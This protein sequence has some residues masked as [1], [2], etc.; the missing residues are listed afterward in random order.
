MSYVGV[1]WPLKPT[2]VQ[3]ALFWQYVG[4]ARWSYN[5]ALDE[6]MESYHRGDSQRPSAIDL[7]KKLTTIKKRPETEWLNSI[8]NRVPEQSIKDA[9]RAFKRFF[10]GCRT[11]QKIGF[12]RRRAKY[13]TKPT[14]SFNVSTR[15]LIRGSRIIVPKIGTVK[16]AQ[17]HFSAPDGGKHTRLTINYQGGQWWAGV[18]YE[19]PG[20]NPVA[21][22][23]PS[24]GVDLGIAALATLSTG[25]KV[26]GPQAF[27]QEMKRLRRKNRRWAA[28]RNGS[29]RKEKKRKAIIRIHARIANVR[30]NSI[31]QLTTRLAKNYGQVVIED[32]A[33]KN[34]AKNRHLSLSIMD[35]GWGM[36]SQ[37]LKYKCPKYGSE[38]IQA[39]Q[40]Y[41][42]SKTCSGCGRK[43]EAL[44]FGQREWMCD[45]CGSKHD[46]DV[47]A[48][49]NLKNLP[50]NMRKVTPVETGGHIRR[51]ADGCQSVKREAKRL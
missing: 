29:K 32:L 21:N 43:N 14:F 15:N 46:R 23:N 50:Q 28:S 16:V 31:H 18:L 47:N 40:F 44:A 37:Q 2:A 25:E 49:I 27:R 8:S 48:A 4:T 11:G 10:L 5:W 41:P 3:E 39:N 1:K 20:M 51:K 9:D 33:I 13:K 42:S 22:G 34:M 45:G 30:S 36:F 38:L 6:W 19:V 35:A 24:V 12:P 17:R 7:A 26:D